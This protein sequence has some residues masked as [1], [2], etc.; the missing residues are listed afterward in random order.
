MGAVLASVYSAV[1]GDVGCRM[2]AT[3]CHPG[4]RRVPCLPDGSGMRLSAGS[5]VVELWRWSLEVEYKPR[6]S[7]KRKRRFNPA[8]QFFK[9]HGLGCGHWHSGR[10]FSRNRQMQ[11]WS[12]SCNV[13]P[14]RSSQK[15]KCRATRMDRRTTWA[16]YPSW[17][18][19]CVKSSR[20]IT[21]RLEVFEVRTELRTTLQVLIAGLERQCSPDSAT[22][23]FT[24][25]PAQLKKKPARLKSELRITANRA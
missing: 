19:N 9:S 23:P 7:R 3:C 17:R 22:L 25:Q 6:L 14:P 4:L 10:C 18:R 15:A 5:A 21:S 2:A 1:L 8:R 13:N 24:P 12:V 16:Q 20:I 11:S